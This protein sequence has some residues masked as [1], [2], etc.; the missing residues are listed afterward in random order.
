VGDA[1]DLDLVPTG[2]L[3]RW[4]DARRLPGTGAPIEDVTRLSGGAA[5]VIFR[6]RRG[7]HA[8]VLRRPPRHPRPNSME[9]MLREA[10]VLGALR[11]TGVPHPR[12]VAACADPD[13]IGA[14]FYLMEPVDGFTPMGALPEPFASDPS[15]RR[16]MGFELV[17]AIAKLAQ[18]DYRAV[19]LEG[20]GKPDGFLQRQVGRWQAQLESYR[21]LPGY[22][23][24]ELPG[25]AE[26]SRWLAA[27]LP[28]DFRPGIL[29]GD[30]QFANV[31]FRRDRPELA[32]V[33]DWELSTIGDPLLDLGW[34]L[35]TWRDPDEDGSGA[36]LQPWSG[37]PSRAELTERY[38]AAT[39]RDPAAVPYFRVLGCYKLGILLE[40]NYARGLAGLADRALGDVM[41]GVTWSL[42]QQAQALVQ[43]A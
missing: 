25:F 42:F 37:F 3:A 24:R 33:I 2:A 21:K 11:D 4:M 39:G 10:R 26:V 16:A 32:A 20:F 29:H 15:A 18:V 14:T 35:C 22:A 38:L 19:G 41:G 6:L 36:Y 27:N 28:K 7:A 23:G 1:N 13:V 8:F 31:M 40:G 5:N 34:I 12:L 17:D 43:S 9:T 30:Y